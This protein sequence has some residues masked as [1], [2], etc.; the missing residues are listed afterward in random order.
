MTVV[1]PGKG[2]ATGGAI[3]GQGTGTSDSI[4]AML[5]DGEYVIKASSAA[6]LGTRFLDA[7]N[8]GGMST[9]FRADGGSVGFNPNSQKSIIDTWVGAL[10]WSAETMLSSALTLKNVAEDNGITVAQ[11]KEFG[12]SL[13]NFS[14]DTQAL[15]KANVSPKTWDWANGAV[16]ATGGQPFTPTSSTGKTSTPGATSGSSVVEENTAAKLAAAYETQRVSML[17]TSTERQGTGPSGRSWTAASAS[18]SSRTALA[19]RGSRSPGPRRWS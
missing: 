2:F 6:K 16:S 8:A 19:P 1:Q 3:H 7:I 15:I 5:S 9:V 10:N 14:T 17:G 11:L 12:Y 13:D 18:C 4:P